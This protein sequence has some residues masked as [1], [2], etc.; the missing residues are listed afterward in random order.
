MLRRTAYRV[1]VLYRVCRE[2]AFRARVRRSA[3]RGRVRIAGLDVRVLDPENAAVMATDIF[4]RRIYDFHA[5]TF[6]P[7][8]VDAGSN[9][10]L[11]VLRVKQ[12]YPAARVVGFEPDARTFAVLSENIRANGLADV[13]LVQAAVC[14]VDGTA[15]FGGA[16]DYDAALDRFAAAGEASDEVQTV[17]LRPWLEGP[18]DLLKLNIEGAEWETLEDCADLL[19][20]VS[21]LIVEYHHEPGLART[22]HRILG[23]LH[24]AG[25][26]Y[27]V[28]D[29]DRHTSPGSHPPFALDPS[30]RYYVLVYAKRPS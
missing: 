15:R 18:V 4:L 24:D 22:L 9:I 2:A 12:L 1:L 21:E 20:N 19:P 7:F 29:F 23:L 5:A 26:E 3:S 28:H 11:S 27:I 25:F 16:H 13:E 6:D 8:V 30:S 14:A 17:R 10:G